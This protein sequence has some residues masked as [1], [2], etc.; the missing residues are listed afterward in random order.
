[1]LPTLDADWTWEA[2]TAAQVAADPWKSPNTKSEIAK[3]VARGAVAGIRYY[4]ME[5]MLQVPAR[6]LYPMMKRPFPSDPWREEMDSLLET[7]RIE[8][9]L[10]RRGMARFPG[11]KA[12]EAERFQFMCEHIRGQLEDA[13]SL[14]D[15]GT[16]AEMLRNRDLRLAD[17][18]AVEHYFDLLKSAE[19]GAV[20]FPPS[21]LGDE[22]SPRAT[23]RK[24]RDI[25][26]VLSGLGLEPLP[27][28]PPSAGGTGAR[29]KELVLARLAADPGLAATLE[30]PP[31][32]ASDL[33]FPDATFAPAPAPATAARRPRAPGS[34]VSKG[35][36]RSAA[37]AVN[38]KL[39]D[40]G[41]EF[42]VAFE[43][44]RLALEGRADLAARVAWTA[45]D[46]GDGAGYDVAS[47]NADGMVRLIEVKTT[48][49]DAATAFFV[50]A[51]E[52]RVSAA[53]PGEYWLYRVYDF[54][55]PTRAMY[56][57]QGAL[58]GGALALEPVAYRATPCRKPPRL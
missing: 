1:M 56:R 18:Q 9:W 29:L 55:K 28:Y 2:W 36:D 48:N 34:R 22:A 21:G 31:P 19:G 17:E 43:R 24:F 23:R 57:L 20:P 38:R 27:G 45:R 44:R 10:S 50:T 40:A 5:V 54:A 16:V 14:A 39:G 32:D 11:E 3:M 12:K 7:L 41:E 42:V 52:V 25:A 49:G 33:P 58:D 30:P 53:R 26:A 37:D 47:F 6:E 8:A 13:T 4:E 51:N 46:V 35:Y 15:P